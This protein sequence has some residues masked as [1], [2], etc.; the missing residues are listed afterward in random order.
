MAGILYLVATPIG[1]LEDITLRALRVLREVDV[2]A[3]EDT[4]QTRKLLSHF[5]IKT[6]LIS[7]HEHSGEHATQDVIRQL[8]DEGR[9]VALVT[10]AGTPAVSDPGFE[11]V[12]AA[13]AAGITVCPI[14]GA[15]SV[16][17][18][19]I[20]SG[21]PPARFAFEGFLPRTRSTRLEKLSSL[22]HMQR[23]IIFFESPQRV[24]ETLAELQRTF[25]PDRPACVARE[26][27]KLFEE[28]RRGTLA[29][30]ASF[31]SSD[32][33]RGECVIVVHGAP[34]GADIVSGDSLV[35]ESSRPNELIRVLAQALGVDRRELY[36][37][38]V[39]LKHRE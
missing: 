38:V 35:D 30:L 29:E 37:A 32:K 31:Y 5:D 22:A 36:Q 20:A 34:D 19:L 1:N 26:I 14:P 21:L 10:D 39:A 28:F 4:R 16:L 17:S 18:A 3:A 8:R 33:T 7:Y 2:V 6:A 12:R 11:L 24:S 23:T 15:S 27:T 25:G 13:I 9:T